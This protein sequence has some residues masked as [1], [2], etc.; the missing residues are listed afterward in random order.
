MR[1]LLGVTVVVAMTGA[2]QA[3]V[4]HR[5]ACTGP[6]ARCMAEMVVDADGVPLPADPADGFGGSDLQAAYGIDATA[7]P[8]AGSNATIAVVDAFGYPTLEADLALYRAQYNLPPCT[9][10]SGCLTILNQSGQASPLPAPDSSQD[11]QAWQFE[12]ALDLDMASAMCPQCKLIALEA[13]TDVDEG[14]ELA[15]TTTPP[16]SP[17]RR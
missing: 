16:R 8:L 10:A 14:L 15:R 5:H 2:A 11:G 4:R 6:H 13:N 9:V 1:A 12:S 17:A 7:S 3:G